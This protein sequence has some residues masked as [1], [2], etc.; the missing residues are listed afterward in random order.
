MACVLVALGVTH[1]VTAQVFPGESGRVAVTRGGSATSGGAPEC[2]DTFDNDLDGA[3]DFPADAGCVSRVD[4][5]EADPSAAPQP[6]RARIVLAVASAGSLNA[7][8]CGTFTGGDGSLE[9]PGSDMS[10]NT[11]A[12][13]TAGDGVANDSRI[14]GIAEAV[15][16]AAAGHPGVEL[17]LLRTFQQGAAFACPTSDP[18][19]VSGGWQGATGTCSGAFGA[20]EL[21]VRFGDDD[22][23][24]LRAWLDHEAG[25]APAIPPPGF[26][27][28]LR[29][30]GKRALAAL[31][32]DAGAVAAA[33]RASDLAGSCRPYRVVVVTDGTDDCGGDA[34]RA[35]TDVRAQGVPVHVVAYAANSAP[36]NGIAMAGGTSA[37]I[38]VDD[39]P[40]LAA[41][42]SQIIDDATPRE[43]CNGLDDDCDGAIDEEFTGLGESCGNGM[44]G[45]CASSGA[46][47]CAANG[48]TTVCALP[49]AASP[50]PET[51]NRIDDDC[52]G[53]IDEDGVCPAGVE[54]CNGIDDDGDMAVDED[55]PV[56]L[57]CSDGRTGRCRG[58]GAYRC[59]ADGSA[60]TCVIHSPGGQP[61]ASDATC[62]GIDDD[63]DGPVDEEAVGAMELISAGTTFAID[64]YEASRPDADAT[65]AGVLEH[66]ACSKPAALPWR[67]VTH[68]EAVVACAA[69][70]KRLCGDGEWQAACGGA[71]RLR[72]PYGSVY[73]PQVCNGNDHDPDCTPPDA[74]VAIPTGTAA[75]C[76]PSSGTCTGTTGTVDA[77]GNVAEWTATAVGLDRRRVRGG[78]FRSTELALT[79]DYTEL[80]QAV[81]VRAVDVGFRCCADAVPSIPVASRPAR[82]GAATTNASSVGFEVQF[83]E[84]VTGVGASDFVLVG[85]GAT[86]ATIGSVAA[87]VA[88]DRFVITIGVGVDGALGLDLLADGTIRSGTGHALAN[89][90]AGERYTIDRTAPVPSTSVRTTTTTASPVTFAVTFSEPV[91]GIDVSDF[92]V[93]TSGSLAGT[94][95]TSVT[96]SGAGP[97]LVTV[98]ITSG[99]GTVRIERSPASAAQDLA[100]NGLAGAFATSESYF[101]DLG[102]A[103]V[104]ANGFE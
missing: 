88:G 93:V 6:D 91:T 74:D 25:G 102:N 35:A 60:A 68:D 70:G 21:L 78:G 13:P 1:P 45:A 84:P 57:Q 44:L 50:L 16:R 18:T 41:A 81:D 76:P 27:F 36:L 94:V 97:Y 40:E 71:A 3:I 10:P 43:T 90:S 19:S 23:V 96:G 39:A 5:S 26:D 30:T 24:A 100:G 77:S 103:P 99:T 75:A 92:A 69:A 72:Y 82:T 28:E 95:V 4:A 22:L 89:G 53:A 65:R 59:L 104:F 66:R 73:L 58:F 12:T 7:D 79:C 80:S 52:D 63:C 86:G 87:N 37:A 51:C 29:A 32:R 15:V 9:C 34:M 83:S 38:A 20:G 55:F 67:N 48:Q 56:G 85:A 61:A 42:L 33:A 8:A 54:R 46:R 64:R 31:I 14:H 49:P 101:V 11:C 2:A 98:A 47:S 17:A 62:D